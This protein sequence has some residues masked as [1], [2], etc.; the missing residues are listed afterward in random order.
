VRDRVTNLFGQHVSPQV[1]ERLMADGPGAQSDIRR[2]AVRFVDFQSFTAGARD[3]SPQEVVDRLRRRIRRA[4]R[5]SRS[6]WRH[7]EQVSR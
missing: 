6:S 7:R 1:V 3:R 5:Y 4:G 2:V